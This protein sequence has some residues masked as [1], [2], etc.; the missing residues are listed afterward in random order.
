VRIS[1]YVQKYLS[2]RATR[3]GA[4]LLAELCGLGD[5]MPPQNGI[6]NSHKEDQQSTQT[7]DLK[8]CY[9]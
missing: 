1:L 3:F 4:A 7:Q 9:G 8:T 2:Y 5:V 6:N